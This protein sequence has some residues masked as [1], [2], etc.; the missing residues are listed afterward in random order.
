MPNFELHFECKEVERNVLSK[1][2]FQGNFGSFPFP[3]GL[4]THQESFWDG[5]AV[6]TPLVAFSPGFFRAAPCLITGSL[7][8]IDVLGF[9][10][11]AL[12]SISQEQALIAAGAL[13]AA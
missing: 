6:G 3:Y 12:M 2:S 13:W 1:V 5:S 8:H 4:S 10:G 11:F 7:A 9:Q